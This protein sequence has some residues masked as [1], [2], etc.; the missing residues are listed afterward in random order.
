VP[1][2]NKEDSKIYAKEA[3]H[4][5]VEGHRVAKI[6]NKWNWAKAD[7]AD[8][9]ASDGFHEA[10]RTL[11]PVQYEIFQTTQFDDVTLSNARKYAVDRIDSY[12][13][14]LDDLAHNART[15]S[16]RFNSIMALLKISGVTEADVQMEFIELPPKQVE[17]IAKATG[18]VFSQERGIPLRRGANIATNKDES[19]RT[20]RASTRKR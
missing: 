16:V 3:A 10:L 20:K 19:K 11:D 6:A 7:V 14:D 17:I 18:A 2:L 13:E 12:M 8:L 15:E 9:L 1:T 5:W 4:L